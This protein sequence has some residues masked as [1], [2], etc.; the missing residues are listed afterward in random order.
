M[1]KSGAFGKPHPATEEEIRDII[2]RFVHVAVYLQKSVHDGVQLHS[3]HGYPSSTP[4][5]SAL[6]L[7]SKL[8]RWNSKNMD[9][10]PRSRRNYRTRR[11]VTG[12]FC[13]ASGMVQALETV[14]GV[15][16][17][18]SITQEP[19]LPKELLAGTV[20]GAIQQKIDPQNFSRQA[21]LVVYGCC[22]SQKTK[23]RLT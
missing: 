22:G 21:L 7:E 17:G 6:S 14:D 5:I 10:P 18:R 23:N 19:R 15:G 8:T 9:L 20:Q 2:H 12:G 1:E 13:T 16:L 4:G 11:Y 3:A